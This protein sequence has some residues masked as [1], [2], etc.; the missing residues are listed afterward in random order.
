MRLPAFDKR[1][2]LGNVITLAALVG[3][4]LVTWGEMRANANSAKERLDALEKADHRQVK[5]QESI[6]DRLSVIQ[7]T[8]AALDERSQAQQRQLD[9]IERAVME[10]I[11]KASVP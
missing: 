4:G 3:G 1:L 6:K 7:S 5:T 11:R 10:S 9:R 8:V 2:S